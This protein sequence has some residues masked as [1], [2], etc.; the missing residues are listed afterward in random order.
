MSV[1]DPAQQIGEI[2]VVDLGNQAVVRLTNDLRYDDG[3]VVSPSGDV[4]AWESCAAPFSSCRIVLARKTVLGWDVSAASGGSGDELDPATDGTFVVWESNAGDANGWDVYWRRVDS[5][6]VH[7]LELPDDQFHPSVAGGVIAFE[8]QDPVL[9]HSDVY[10][11]DIPTNRLYRVTHLATLG[12]TGPDVS[13]TLNDISA[14]PTGEVRVVWQQDDDVSS[15]I[16]SNNIYAATIRLPPRF[17][18]YTDP[19]AF[20]RDAGA[21]T[22]VDFDHDAC[23]ATVPA[24]IPPYPAGSSYAPLGVTFRDGIVGAVGA[25]NALGD[26]SKVV[27]VEFSAPVLAAGLSVLSGVA[28]GGVA[29]FPPT[30]SMTAYDSAGQVISAF[31]NGSPTFLGITSVTPIARLEIHVGPGTASPVIDDLLFTTVATPACAAPPV[32]TAALTPSPNAAGWN[33]TTVRLDLTSVPGS[34]GAPVASIDVSLSGASTG[35]SFVPGSTASLT[36][37]AE[38]ITT[39]TYG[40]T[41]ATGAVET[42]RS[43]AVRIDLTPPALQLPSSITVKAT[44]PSGASVSYAASATDALDPQPGLVCAPPSP[45]PFPV[46]TTTVSCSA[47]D[48][49]GN[50]ASGTFSIRVKGAADQVQDL[51]AQVRALHL[52]PV[53]EATLLAPLE[54]ALLAARAGNATLACVSMRLFEQVVSAAGKAGALPQAASLIAA[55]RDVRIALGCP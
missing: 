31:A 35:N 24:A 26:A 29:A 50:L 13:A 19:A 42:A 45:S 48:A 17:G 8:S 9:L 16:P 49:A 15:V 14:L 12:P 40:A 1:V 32:T 18:T 7:R 43:L 10:L 39:I 46:G 21:L 53:L 4:I 27:S 44:G 6:T 25:S 54:V 36:L 47:A 22:R 33:R 3:P 55:A 11:Y 2:F 28:P 20:G 51:I 38:G 52:R 34:G 23:G 30:A 37:S 41:S 5:P